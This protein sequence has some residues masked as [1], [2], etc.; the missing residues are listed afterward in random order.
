MKS[1]FENSSLLLFDATSFNSYVPAFR[2]IVM[3]SSTIYLIPKDEDTTVLR[4]AGKHPNNT[5]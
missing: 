3:L 2:K 4:N 1:E 5:V